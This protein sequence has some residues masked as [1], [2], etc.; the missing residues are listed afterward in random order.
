ML[1]ITK[2]LHGELMRSLISDNHRVDKYSPFAH[3]ETLCRSDRGVRLLLLHL[4]RLLLS[5]E[6]L[7]ADILGNQ[8]S[9]AQLCEIFFQNCVTM[10][11]RKLKFVVVQFETYPVVTLLFYT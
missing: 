9:K 7:T 3:G 8:P 10:F 2:A 5:K 4:L 11:F 6:Q 1:V